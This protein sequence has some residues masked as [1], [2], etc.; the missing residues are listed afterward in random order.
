MTRSSFPLYSACVDAYLNRETET[1]ARMLANPDLSITEKRLLETRLKF[2]DSRY[3]EAAEILKT[4]ST[5]GIPFLEAERYLLLGNY[6][7]YKGQWQEALIAN[8][9][10]LIGYESI[11]DRRGAFLANY[12]LSVDYGRL[13]LHQAAEHFLRQAEKGAEAASERVLVLRAQASLHG[14]RGRDSRSIENAVH[15]I[16]KALALQC[17]L[18][19]VD[20]TALVLVAAD[21]Y[22]RAN[23]R[24]KSYELLNGIRQVKATR[25]RA[26]ILF[27]LA[28]LEML[29]NG[30]P[31]FTALGGA[32]SAVEESVEYSL[33]WSIIRNLQI[34]E[35]G[36][37]EELW[38][39]LTS[40]ASSRYEAK[41]T[42]LGASDNESL[43]MTVI[44]AIRNT[45]CANSWRVAPRRG[46]S[47]LIKLIDL[48]AASEGPLR[49]ENLIE[50]I[51][52]VEYDP[53]FDARFYKLIERARR[54][55]GL[56]LVNVN[57]AYLIR[58]G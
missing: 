38:D 14:S 28:L 47:K 13:S 5:S 40:M 29:L 49:K 41:F 37:A 55:C 25:D 18:N 53:S 2:R 45:S 42:A 4:L 58:A 1:L 36:R 19:D 24:H 50:E 11:R 16:E 44:G 46:G 48:L 23:Q 21:I 54:E 34:G 32:P 8:H 33:K 17:E 7:A 30:Q 3:D 35:L 31:P 43:F 57:Q 52:G 22:F 9:Q 6:H 51:W 15:V 39:E 27:D 56:E 12:N 10:A 26:R 20:R